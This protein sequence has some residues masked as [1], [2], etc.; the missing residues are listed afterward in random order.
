MVSIL[1][2][3]GATTFYYRTHTMFRYHKGTYADI[4]WF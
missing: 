4:W 3:F 1:N 2:G